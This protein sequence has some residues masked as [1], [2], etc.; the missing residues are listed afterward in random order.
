M[1]NQEIL[2]KAIQ[3]AIDGG[4]GEF[5]SDMNVDGVTYDMG[6]EYNLIFNHDFAKALWGG[7]RIEPGKQAPYGIGTK[8]NG[9]VASWEYHLMNMVISEDP[10]KYLGDNIDE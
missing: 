8:H 7:S 4:W 3:K 6:G 10:I 5:Y 9:I 2:Q 1:S